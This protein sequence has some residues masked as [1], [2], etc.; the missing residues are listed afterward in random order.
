MIRVAAPPSKSFTHRAYLLAAQS[1]QPCTVLRPLRA[2]HTDG[3][4]RALAQMG[5]RFEAAPDAVRFLPASLR[6][7]PGAVQCGASAS[8]MR[9]VAAA[10]ARFPVAT[11]LDGDAALRARPQADLVTALRALGV[12]ADAGPLRVQGPLLGGSVAIPPGASSQVASGLLLALAQA[13]GPSRLAARAPVASR[14]YLDV[15]LACMAAFGLTARAAD[16]AGAWVADL[17]GGEG[18]RCAR[19]EVE[20]DW[21]AAAMLLCAAAIQGE[22]IEVAGVRPDSVQGD[23]AIVELLARFG[24]PGALESP[25]AIDVAAV[26]DLF[27][28]LAAVAAHARGTTTFTGGAALRAKESDRIAA[29]ADGL[30]A[31]GAEVQERPDG[32]VVRG[33]APLRLAAVASRG[34]HRVHMALAIAGGRPDGDAGAS[35]PGFAHAL[36]AL[37][38]RA[39]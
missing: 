39:A 38:Q 5:A 2:G 26:P 3:T 28:P 17:P 33:G 21:S 13:P 14:P 15:T 4:L 31:L 1:D 37:R 22:R 10:A 29:M 30:R 23:R 9:L 27:P 8:T 24:T 11:V 20:G 7:P 18:P 12:R 34:D 32:L 19:F 36:A 16:T 25:G 6:P 35:F